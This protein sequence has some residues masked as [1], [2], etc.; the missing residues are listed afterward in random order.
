LFRWK[1]IVSHN[2]DLYLP[3]GVASLSSLRCL[4]LVEEMTLMALARATENVGD[5]AVHARL[6]QARAARA[7]RLYELRA[8]GA[9]I[10]TLGAY[11]NVRARSTVAT[12]GGVALSFLGVILVVA[13]VAWPIK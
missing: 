3:C 11:Y 9:S 6:G 13:A 8:A 2:P 7:A 12:Y 4:T 10:V 1:N 5:P